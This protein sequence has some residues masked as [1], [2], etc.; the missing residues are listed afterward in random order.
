MEKGKINRENVFTN[1]ERIIPYIASTKLASYSY[2][3]E[4]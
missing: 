3:S 1:Q 2:E 4:A